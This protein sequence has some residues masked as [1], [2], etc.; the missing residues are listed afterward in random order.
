VQ[1][2]Y[3]L[4]KDGTNRRKDGTLAANPMRLGPLTMEARRSG[5][6]QVLD[7]QALVNAA[8]E[9][10]E[11]PY[12]DLINTREHQRIL[13]LIAANTWPERWTGR[14]IRGDVLVL[15]VIA[16]GIMQPLLEEGHQ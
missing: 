13:E 9:P 15:Q 11:R 14:E 8:A 6:A 2:K 1:P 5:L 3:R 4:R 16:N 12:I 10:Q 7:I